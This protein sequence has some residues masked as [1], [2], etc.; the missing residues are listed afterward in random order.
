MENLEDMMSVPLKPVEEFTSSD[1]HDLI[2]PLYPSDL[3]A[4]LSSLSQKAPRV[5]GSSK[6]EDI[7]TTK[8]SFYIE[9]DADIDSEKRTPKR[10]QENSKYPDSCNL[11]QSL[12]NGA[13]QGSEMN[14]KSHRRNLFE[15]FDSDSNSKDS[16]VTTDGKTKKFQNGVKDTSVELNISLEKSF[17]KY[18]GN[19]EGTVLSQPVCVL[20]K[21]SCMITEDSVNVNS[22][23]DLTV[24]PRKTFQNLTQIPSNSREVMPNEM[25]ISS[26]KVKRSNDVSHLAENLESMDIDESSHCVLDQEVAHHFSEANMNHLNSLSGDSIDDC[27]TPTNDTFDMEICDKKS[28]TD[29]L[30][31]AIDGNRKSVDSVTARKTETKVAN[32]CASPTPN[33][34]TCDQKL[35]RDLSLCKQLLQR[36]FQH[37]MSQEMLTKNSQKCHSRTYKSLP[38]PDDIKQFQFVMGRSTSAVFNSSTGLPS[39]SSPAPLKK[40]SSTHFDYDCSLTNIRSIK[41]AMSCS[42]LSMRS[43]VDTDSMEDTKVLSTSAPASTNCLLG[44]FE[45]SVLNGRIEP[46]GVVQ[47]FTV[48]IGAS[49][50]FC[51]RHV[52]LPVVSYFFQLSDDNAPSPYLGYVNLEPLGKRGY[53]VPRSGT[54]QVTLFNPNRSVVKMFVVMYDL[55]DMPPNCQTFLRQ[56]TMY[57]SVKENSSEQ[58]YLRYLIHLRFQSRKSGKIYLHTDLR[59]IFARDKFEFDPRVGNYELRSFTEGPENPKFS[60]KR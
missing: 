5:H 25:C 46:V 10:P 37:N 58:S 27:K 3:E 17:N 4:F 8:C 22:Q 59:L 12:S 54:V 16:I 40:R 38:S 2:K 33:S 24:L 55:S 45:E 47:G 50:S 36:E 57:M 42:K 19:T 18:S 43:D 7:P 21:N 1:L 14:S 51:P 28:V 29:K 23:R 41:N 13:M 11:I 30:A 49:G 56:R 39:R 60:P 15:N 44:N 32:S 53:H 20:N 52:T 35:V 6:L 31:C 48:E 26:P 34:S 9:E